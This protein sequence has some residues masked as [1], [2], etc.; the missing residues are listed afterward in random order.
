MGRICT[1][2]QNTLKVFFL[3][4][5]SCYEAETSH[6]LVPLCSVH[7]LYA[8]EPLADSTEFLRTSVQYVR[9]EV[10]TAVTMKNAVFWDVTPCGSCKNRYFGGT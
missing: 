1:V 10:L 5:A 4:R 6:A 2:H 7:V 9:F 8:Y 3:C